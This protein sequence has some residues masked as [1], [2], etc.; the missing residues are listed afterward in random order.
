MTLRTCQNWIL[1]IDNL[2]SQK[3]NLRTSSNNCSTTVS[4]HHPCNIHFK[5]YFMQI[6]QKSNDTRILHNSMG[7][8]III[9]RIKSLQ[10]SCKSQ[11]KFIC[12]TLCNPAIMQ[13]LFK[14]N[15]GKMIICGKI[16][17]N[18][19]LNCNNIRALVYFFYTLF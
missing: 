2:P 4:L 14:V 9:G 13:F 8:F 19:I 7:S 17:Q 1:K 12:L 10:S 15:F 3:F 5:N 6:L 18:K 16:W 11:D